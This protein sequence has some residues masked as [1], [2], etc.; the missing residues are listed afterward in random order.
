MNN[1][2]ENLY[3]LSHDDPEEYQEE[4]ARRSHLKSQNKIQAMRE[5]LSS[6]KNNLEGLRLY[7]EG[8][9]CE[10]GVGLVINMQQITAEGLKA[11]D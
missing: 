10:R 2:D 1:L 11:A 6:I 5:S 4:L 7:L 3:E 8:Y 9:D